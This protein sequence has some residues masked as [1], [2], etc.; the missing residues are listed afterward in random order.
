MYVELLYEQPAK[1][2]QD[3]YL[4]PARTLLMPQA[5]TTLILMASVLHV[6]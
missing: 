2:S 1:A 5:G 4:V 3:G 6:Y